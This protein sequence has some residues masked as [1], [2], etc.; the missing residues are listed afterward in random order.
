MKDITIA[1]F[2]ED[3]SSKKPVPGGGGASALIGAVSAA[4]CSMAANLTSGKKKY[5]EYQPDIERILLQSAEK[6]SKLLD[7][8]KKDAEVFEPLAAA[9]RI[10]KDEPDRDERLESALVKACSVPMEILKEAA[11]LLA[12]VEELSKK[13]TKLA[14]S[15][16]G[17]SACACRS[18]IEGAVMNVY[19]NTKLMKNRSYALQIN[20][21]ATDIL[22]DGITGCN[23]IYAKITD[24]L[25]AE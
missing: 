2:I 7:L 13:G 23:R 10:P 21:E 16:V 22:N 4:L 25:R 17:V 8:I 9:Y 6:A 14:I 20:K 12:L 3:L 1:K 24:E 11:G 5:A 19:I 15:D 18:A